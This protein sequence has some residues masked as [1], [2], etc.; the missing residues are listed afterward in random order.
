MEEGVRYQETMLEETRA[1]LAAEPE[2]LTLEAALR[3]A[4][5]RSLRQAQADIQAMIAKLDRQGARNTFLP[6]L[7]ARFQASTR[8]RDLILI[9]DLGEMKTSDSSQ[10]TGGLHLSMPI[11]MPNAWLFYGQAL[12]G[13]RMQALVAERS[14]QMLNVQV[15]SAFYNACSAE[16]QAVALA[17]RSV[18]LARLEEESAARE[19]QGLLNEAQMLNIRLMR[20]GAD[21]QRDQAARNV[22]LQKAYFMELLNLWPLA[23][24]KLSPVVPAAATNGLPVAAYSAA[25]F[26]ELPLEA[27][28]TEAVVERP[29][30]RVGDLQIE[31]NK[32]DVKRAIANF[33]PQLA[34]FGEL[35]GTT[36]S[37]VKYPWSLVAGVE[38][39]MTLFNG[40][41][42]ISDYRKAKQNV[43]AAELQLEEKTLSVM[44]QVVEA[45][46]N[47]SDVRQLLEVAELAVASARADL[48][49]VAS[50]H[51]QGLEEASTL[52]QS[53]AALASAEASLLQASYGERIACYVFLS[54]LGH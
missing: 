26:L 1:A 4:Q 48:H 2:G 5:E 54:A 19:R 45:Y 29:E 34:G 17:A 42:T 43:R 49:E 50:R 40:F 37:Y 9:S 18:A 12:R 8:A 13:E 10:L 51:T 24:V 47:L 36:D 46:K 30:L 3:I 38:G 33:L 31:V 11:F 39:T 16:D 52:Y 28:I 23:D 32:L 7:E 53:Q 21:V 15:A 27:W 22:P 41:K 20:A 6:Q 44:L 14:R 35:M 25:A